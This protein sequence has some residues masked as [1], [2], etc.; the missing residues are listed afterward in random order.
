MVDTPETFAA[1]LI[2]SAGQA[3]Q[4]T[5]AIVQKGA[6]NVKNQAKVNVQ[7]TAPIRHAHAHTAINY[8]TTIKATTIEAEIGYDKD[9][10]PGRLG[11]LLEFGGRGDHSPPHR[12]LAL[13]LEAEEPRF[14]AAVSAL[15][16]KLL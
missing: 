2:K 6:L 12:D 5:R 10:R 9:K 13:A 8:D 3:I 14:E 16:E 4:G 1:D 11:N 7:K 15:A